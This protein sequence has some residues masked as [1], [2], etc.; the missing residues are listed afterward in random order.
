MLC[1]MQ[2]QLCKTNL[3]C[4]RM[5]CGPMQEP[6]RIRY[7]SYETDLFDTTTLKDPKGFMPSTLPRNDALKE[8]SGRD[9]WRPIFNSTVQSVRKPARNRRIVLYRT[10]NRLFISSVE[11]GEKQVR[12]SRRRAPVNECVGIKAA[13]DGLGQCYG[14]NTLPTGEW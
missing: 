13:I 3:H 11:K 6:A 7:I 5:L 10:R 14:R 2:Y 8:L 9:L 4:P 12:V 1:S